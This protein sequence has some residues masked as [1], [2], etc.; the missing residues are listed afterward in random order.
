MQI[1]DI[2]AAERAQFV[3]ATV[4]VVQQFETILGKDLVDEARK[5][6]GAA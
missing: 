4:P 6:L 5:A 2:T 1:N 3:E